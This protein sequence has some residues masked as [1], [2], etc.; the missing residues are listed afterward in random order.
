MATRQAQRAARRGEAPAG[1]E[2]LRKRV[3]LVVMCVGLFLVQLD[4]TIVNVALPHI[5][6][7]LHTGVAGLQW[8]VD[9]Y[10]IAFASLLLAG[11]TLGDLLGR[12]RVVLAGLLVFGLGSL[13]CGVAPTITALVGARVLQGV[14]AALL[15]PGT[16]AV[17]TNAH[18]DRGEQARAIGAWAA[19][20]GVALPAGPLI[21]GLLVDTLGW[22]SVFLVNLPVAAIGLPVT[23]RFVRESSDPAGRRLDAPG[24]LLGALAL[25]SI[26]FAFIEA[27]DAGFR[28]PLVPGA[29][30]AALLLAAAF[31]LVERR[32]RSPLLPIA[33]FRSRVFSAA[34]AAAG[35]MNLSALGMIF[36][37]TLY[38]QDVRRLPALVA[39]LAIVP[40]FALLI[41]LAPLGG[42][43]TARLGSRPPMLAG[44]LVA[45]AGM[46]MLTRLDA[47]SPYPTVLLP[48]LVLIGAGLGLLTPAV[49]AAAM[50]AVDA[51]RAGLAS[52]VNNTARQAGGA[53]GIATFG[54]LAGAPT[55]PGAFLAGLHAAALVG[56]GLYAAAAAAT[57]AFVPGGADRP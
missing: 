15:L 57:A 1:G 9:G 45:A 25:A 21:G 33:L 3:T 11:G 27:G 6:S 29:F 22:R 14:G 52:G 54:A 2:R 20:S 34:N 7:G 55:D 39:G 17:I 28:S 31:V 43:L 30:A 19:V 4:V 48:P 41:G 24:L 56:A 12:R 47:A 18:P 35:A 5:A 44:L 40:V 13:A 49:V 51:A 50:R 53:I 8:V 38:L 26:T 23:L 36:V 42:R 37:L 46:L 32:R 16:L 10:A